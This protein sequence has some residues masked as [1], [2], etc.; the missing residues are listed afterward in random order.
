[1]IYNATVADLIRLLSLVKIYAEHGDSD[2]SG[3]ENPDIVSP[4]ESASSIAP[5]PE[6]P[7]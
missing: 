7:A 4:E 1:M 3:S 5:Q 2:I 6:C